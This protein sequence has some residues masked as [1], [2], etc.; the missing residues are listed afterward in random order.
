MD[1]LQVSLTRFSL[2][3]M[4]KRQINS[5]SGVQGKE[6]KIWAS[7]I[8]M[9]FSF[10]IFKILSEQDSIFKKEVKQQWDERGNLINKILNYHSDTLLFQI[11]WDL[12]IKKGF[13]NLEIFILNIWVCSI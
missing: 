10:L 5:S 11:S 6:V 13:K 3:G 2:Q 4:Q 1:G 12:E 7:N 9:F 8:N